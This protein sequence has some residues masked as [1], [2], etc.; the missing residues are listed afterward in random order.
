MLVSAILQR[1]PTWW[2]KNVKWLP[3]E[4]TVTVTKMAEQKAIN[5]LFFDE[6]KITVAKDRF[7]M[8]I[9]GCRLL[10]KNSIHKLI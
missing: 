1:D 4:C 3:R 10:L 7:F 9:S 8:L 5:V 6:A 2:F